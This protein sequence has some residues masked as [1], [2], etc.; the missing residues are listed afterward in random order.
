MEREL[1]IRFLRDMLR[2]RRM[3]ERI[4]QE[5]TRGNIGGFLHLYPGEESV[6]IGVLA[7]AEPGDYIVSTYREHVHALA[8]GMP[9]RS[10]TA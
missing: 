8:R 6:A 7:A 10:I 9:M 3:E 4:A 1:H 2:A 5:Y